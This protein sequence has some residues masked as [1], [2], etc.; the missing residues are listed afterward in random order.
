MKHICYIIV[1][2]VSFACLPLVCFA[3]VT[4]A[5]NG[6]YYRI[7]TDKTNSVSVIQPLLGSYSSSSYTIP[8]EVKNEN[9]ESYTVTGID[10]YAFH[11]CRDLTEIV[12]PNTL[13]YI[14]THAFSFTSLSK[15]ELPSSLQKIGDYAF[16]SCSKITSLEL[17]TSI[18]YI[19][20]SAFDGCSLTSIFVP[21][22]VVSLGHSAFAC[23]N[24]TTIDVEEGNRYYY[25]VENSNAIFRSDTLYMGCKATKV[26]PMGITAVDD[27]AFHS[28]RN[29]T[30][31]VFPNTLT[32]IG[33]HA[34][35]FTSLS[36]IE[37]PSS[38]QKIG[39][40]AFY[41]C[42]KMT[43]VVTNVL[44][45]FTICESVFSDIYD[46]AKLFV[47]EGTVDIYKE[48]DGWKN[49][50]NIREIEPNPIPVI[51]GLTYVIH[52]RSKYAEIQSAGSVDHIVIP[53]SVEYENV[54]YPVTCVQD[55]AFAK[56]DMI[57]LTLPNSITSVGAGIVE[58][59]NKLAA[60]F[61]G[62]DMKP[63]DELVNSIINH[64]LLFYVT[65][66]NSKPDD[67]HSFNIIVNGAADIIFL[68]DGDN[69][70]FYCPIA[71][72][73]K[74]AIYTHNYGLQTEKGKCQGWESIALPFDVQVF[75]TLNGETLKPYLIADAGEKRF[76]LRELTESGLVES[77][78]I[79]ANVPYIISMPN[80]EGYQ[81]FYNI[82]GEVVFSARDVRIEPTEIQPVISGTHRFYPA[83]QIQ[84]KNDS[85]YALNKEEYNDNAP[86]S[87]FVKTSRDIRPFE[88]YFTTTGSA[89]AR[90]EISIA[91]LM[92][93]TTAIADNPE[94]LRR[95][96]S[97]NGILYIEDPT[98]GNCNIC[99]ISGQLM[100]KVALKQG[101]NTV[102][103]LSKG[104]YIVNGQKIMVK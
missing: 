1:C 62:L 88:A 47:P 61:W 86:G 53:T 39:N 6:L 41:G 75:Q 16:Y 36:I 32:Y 94:T 14:G 56:L 81:D 25:S 76:W 80:W 71:F 23:D 90:K 65:S 85:I 34:F 67:V 57:S 66:E 100:R 46:K 58:N 10:D 21:K 20:I 51:G 42:N 40:Y 72:T 15:I 87:I 95:V 4:F 12:F 37:L 2:F 98:G 73:A 55:S 104:L 101:V 83:F 97:N 48:T 78:G 52:K 44:H 31:I 84:T 5:V 79:K 26:V 64:N 7:N 38:L 19:G 28:C 50:V 27:Y 99:A 18:K 68:S 24:L 29:L 43:D 91:D 9:G 8:A 63:S 33:T 11:S 92:E 93:S 3:D 17:P 49:F 96:Y 54:Q 70:N 59:C 77:E 30:E 13:T 69:N 89:S 74:N 22:S 103:G 45:P 102:E 82:K 35:S 60:I